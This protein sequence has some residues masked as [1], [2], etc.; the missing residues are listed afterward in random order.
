VENIATTYACSP[1]L[2]AAHSTVAGAWTA[3]GRSPRMGGA[4]VLAPRPTSVEGTGLS[5]VMR[6]KTAI[7]ATAI[8]KAT[9]TLP[10]SDVVVFGDNAGIRSWRP[11]V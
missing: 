8:S 5:I 3:Y 2:A 4:I 6:D 7:A 1:S 9:I 10:N 11:P